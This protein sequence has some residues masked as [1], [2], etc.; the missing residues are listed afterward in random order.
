[1]SSSSMSRSMS[2]TSSGRPERFFTKRQPPATP[3]SLDRQAAQIQE[4][5]QG[6]GPLVPVREVTQLDSV[7]TAR[8]MPRLVPLDDG[9]ERT[10]ERTKSAQIGDEPRSQPGR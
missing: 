5:I 8:T 4:G 3:Q 7:G 2:M 1:M 9:I 10:V 6:N